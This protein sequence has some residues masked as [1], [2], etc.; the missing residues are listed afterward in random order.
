MT[1]DELT[2]IRAMCTHGISLN[3]CAL[4]SSVPA[5]LDEVE[6]LRAVLQEIATLGPCVDMSD[7]DSDQAAD[8]LSALA[9]LQRRAREA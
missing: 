3:E 2:A 1:D 6:R 9:R 5:L 7:D 4:A 8:A